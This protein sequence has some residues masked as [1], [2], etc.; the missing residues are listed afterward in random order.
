MRATERSIFSASVGPEPVLANDQFPHETLVARKHR[1]RPGGRFV[2]AVRLVAVKHKEL[3]VVTCEKCI[4]L[5][6]VSHACPEPV[7]LK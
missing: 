5:L 7:L 6:S 4:S 1:G 3:Q 2:P